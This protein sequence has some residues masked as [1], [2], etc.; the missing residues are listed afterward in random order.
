MVGQIV[1]LSTNT[2]MANQL[3]AVK[4]QEYIAYKSNDIYY[5]AVTD[6][7]E[8]LVGDPQNPQLNDAWSEL[9]EEL[10]LSELVGEPFVESVS[11]NSDQ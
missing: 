6:L 3:E 2:Q 4:P 7:A 5:D 9:L 1:R 8:L 11:I 10:D